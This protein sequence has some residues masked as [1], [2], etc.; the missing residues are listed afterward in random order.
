MNTNEIE[1]KLIQRIINKDEK[2]F[3]ELYK[4]HR[5]KVF[6]FICRRLKDYPLAE[7][8][9]QD[10]FFDLLESL[11]DFRYESSLKT[12]IFSIAKYKTIDAIRGKRM[13]KILFSALP[14]HLIESLRTVLLDEEIE[15]NELKEKI[16]RVFARLPN[17]YRQ[18]LRLKYIEGEKVQQIANRLALN[19]K[20]TESLLFR[21]RKAF[22]TVFN[23]MK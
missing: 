22:V 3:L 21:A 12:L 20:A 6:N 17:D 11:R 23:S 7:E 5:K 4:M 10:V 16:Q 14:E 13:K 2:A 19:F 8:I 15:K 1:K 9:T 18:I